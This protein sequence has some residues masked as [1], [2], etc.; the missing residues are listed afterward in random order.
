MSAFEYAAIFI[1]IVVGLALQNTL[2]S[3]HKLVEAGSRVRWHWMAP[4]AAFGAIVLTLGNFW[5]W[6]LARDLPSSV[7]H[8]FL[9]FLASAMALSLLFLACAATL[10]DE[11]PGEGLDLKDYYFDNRHRMWG[12]SAAYYFV[13]LCIWTA[14]VVQR[15]YQSPTLHTDLIF[16]A[17]NAAAVAMSV[18][19][20][21]VRNWWLHAIWLVGGL[22]FLLLLYGPMPV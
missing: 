11:V 20:I 17:A 2:S 19:L 14:V 10:P 1:G 12:Y 21:V 3:I 18:T 16:V 13:S 9:M 4:V 22:L 7:S 6:W 15:G 5:F 8:S